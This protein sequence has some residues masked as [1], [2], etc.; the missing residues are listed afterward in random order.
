[1]KTNDLIINIMK[2]ILLALLIASMTACSGGGGGGGSSDSTESGTTTEESTGTVIA[3]GSSISGFVADGY[4]TD[5]RVF[6]DRN[7]NRV[8]DNGEPV[9]MSGSDG[10]Y[11]LSI[12]AGEE[13]SYPVIVDVI[14]GQTVDQDNGLFVE[15]DYVLEAPPGHWGFISPIT[16]LVNQELDKNPSYTLQQAVLSIKSQMGIADDISPFDNYLDDVSASVSRSQER[17]RTHRVAQAVAR[18]MGLLRSDI[19]ANIGRSLSP[20]EK[21]L[22]AFMISDQIG[23][24]AGLVKSAIEYERNYATTTNVNDLVSDLY[25]RIAVATLNENLLELYSQ[26][27]EQENDVWDMTP[28]KVVSYSPEENASSSIETTIT[29]RFDED[30]DSSQSADEMFA[31]VGPSGEVSGSLAYDSTLKQLSFT[32]SQLLLP[33]SEYEVVL[34]ATLTDVAGNALGEEISW[35]FTTIFDQTPPELPEF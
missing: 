2:A 13:D 34:K 12:N 1:M 6:L 27:I 20:S 14:A 9:V 11:T 24:Y 35:V 32:P 25:S 8:Y 28:P 33:F 4:L 15:D 23:Q 29:V 26:R 3:S 19:I 21:E 16:T 17:A 31:L 10:S 7:L 30:L 5:A 18:L 22:L